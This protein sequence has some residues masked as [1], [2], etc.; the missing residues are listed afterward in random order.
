MKEKFEGSGAAHLVDA[1]RRLELID[2]SAEI[3]ADVIKAGTLL[4]FKPNEYVVRQNADDDDVYL[5]IA[6]I[7][8]IVVN[9]NTI[10]TR[11]AGQHVGEMAAIEPAQKRS[12]DVVTTE[13]VIA[14]K[15]SSGDFRRICEQHPK[16][17]LHLAKE[18]ARR[19]FARNRDI[20]VPNTSP[21]LFVISSKE[22]LP[23]AQALQAGLE[24]VSLP[25]VW[26]D[27]VFFAGGFALEALEKQVATSDFAVAIAQPD[28]IVESRG[29]QHKTLRDNVLFELGLFMGKL[30]R[31]RS[32]LIHPKV[33]GLHL[34]SDLHGLNTISYQIPERPED[35]AARLGPACTKISHI[36]KAHG[37]LKLLE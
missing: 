22:A 36:I 24:H 1:V 29:Q 13:P 20:P 25:T 37:V 12:A 9:G 7:V 4:E 15:L 31:L 21:R 18:L 3:A 23:V 28:D 6:G 26:T 32:I 8:S 17:W 30:G 27:G 14:L 33:D 11:R 5:L 10:T 19:L 35:L 34:P 16:M 2:G